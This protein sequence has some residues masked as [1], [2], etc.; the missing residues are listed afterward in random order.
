M[1]Y[2]FVGLGGV[3]GSLLRYIVVLISNS[4]SVVG[5]PFG[6]LTANLMGSFIIGWFTSGIVPLKKFP[7]RLKT[8][9]A[10]GMIGSFTTFSTFSVET[11]SMLERNDILLAILY[12]SVSIAG[13][14]SLVQLGDR[15]G[16]LFLASREEGK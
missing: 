10:T 6:T 12:I 13:G 5:F 1:V 9:I 15:I 4:W 7:T 11:V 14:L 16:L 2:L 8:A 3:I